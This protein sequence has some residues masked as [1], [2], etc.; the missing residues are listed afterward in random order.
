MTREIVDERYAESHSYLFGDY[1]LTFTIYKETALNLYDIEII[2]SLNNNVCKI[3]EFCSQEKALKYIEKFANTVMENDSNV[4][5][6]L[7]Q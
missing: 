6:D 2:N 5:M 4:F 1:D 7:I 3:N